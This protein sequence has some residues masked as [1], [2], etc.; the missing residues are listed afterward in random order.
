M[1][2]NRA[3]A[4]PNAGKTLLRALAL[5]L[6]CLVLL[7]YGLTPL[8]LAG[9]PVS[10]PMLW[11]WA[12]GERVERI[13]APIET[14]SPALPLAVLI[15]EDARFCQHS[16]VDWQGVQAAIEDAEDGEIRGASGISQ[17]VAK[18]LFLWQGRSYVRKAL[19]VPLAY[20]ID[21]VLGKRRTLEIYLNVA[22]WGPNG[23]F[24]AEAGARRAFGRSARE[25]TLQQAALLAAIL[26][27]PIRRSAARPR[28]LLLRLAAL[29]EAR[30]LRSPQVDQC[31]RG[32]RG[33]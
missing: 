31:V 5:V 1:P 32:W 29:Y 10:T 13:W 16:G 33:R 25:L 26:P 19:E 8:Y 27:N 22:E 30:A 14:I 20:W 28:A 23:E 11:R 6:A 17:Q 3:V 24:G 21:F 4:P 12:R 9:H 15:A 18:N 7:P 2:L